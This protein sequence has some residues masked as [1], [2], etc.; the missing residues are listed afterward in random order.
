[1]GVSPSFLFA[2][3]ELFQNYKRGLHVV[4]RL[5]RR[6]VR[7]EHNREAVGPLRANLRHPRR[8]DAAAAVP[9]EEILLVVVRL[10]QRLGQS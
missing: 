10:E 1:M 6:I 3:A 4:N 2:I 9:V 7:Q 5:Q 8:H